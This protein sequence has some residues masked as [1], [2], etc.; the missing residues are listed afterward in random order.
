[1][2][3]AASASLESG[4]TSVGVMR[5]FA[6]ERRVTLA[7]VRALGV[8]GGGARGAAE[9]GA[10]SVGA[11]R[12]RLFGALLCRGAT[13]TGTMRLFLG[14]GVRV[15][16]AAPRGLSAVTSFALFALRRSFGVLLRGA[17]GV[18]LAA[19]PAP[20]A[21][22]LGRGR[23]LAAPAEPAEPLAGAPGVTS[24]GRSARSVG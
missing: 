10:M 3:C 19:A 6:T 24:A 4:A 5:L 15:S 17:F 11:M 18:A 22:A 2:L 14:R 9:S 8:F 21:L 23:A 20:L 16:S 13:S 7:G 12:L 1:M